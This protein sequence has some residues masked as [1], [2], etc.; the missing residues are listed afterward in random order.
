MTINQVI[1]TSHGKQ[2]PVEINL[3][4]FWCDFSKAITCIRNNIVLHAY[5]N[6]KCNENRR[7]AVYHASSDSVQRVVS[8]A[9]CV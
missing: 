4:I 2:E 1:G 6:L 9:L 5:F 7:K 3:H 8:Y